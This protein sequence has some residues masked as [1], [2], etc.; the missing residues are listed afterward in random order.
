MNKFQAIIVGA[1]VLEQIT[2][3]V[4]PALPE[5]VKGIHIA[6]LGAVGF[7]VAYGLDIMSMVGL[8]TTVPFLNQVLT[9]VLI[10]TGSSIINTIVEFAQSFTSRNIEG[11]I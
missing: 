6:I 8:Q 11:V 4:K 2:E 5:K 10:S 3:V 7:S 9:G 1:F